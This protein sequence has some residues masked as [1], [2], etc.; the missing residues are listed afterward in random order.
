MSEKIKIQK[1]T[2]GERAI[3]DNMKADISL[4]MEKE[5]YAKSVVKHLREDEDLNESI[6]NELS[7]H[8]EVLELICTKLGITNE[9]FNALCDKVKIAKARADEEKHTPEEE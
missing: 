6:C 3:H 9:E 5:Q 1:M 4:N 8:R 2:P 7:I